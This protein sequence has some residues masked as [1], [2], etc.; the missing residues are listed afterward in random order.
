MA[1]VSV[2]MPT[3]NKALYLDLTLAGFSIQDFLNFELIIVD[4]GSTDSTNEIVNKYFNKINIKYLYQNN[5]GRSCARNKALEMAGSKYII[6]NDDDRIPEPGFISAHHNLL[7]ADSDMINIGYKRVVL[8]YYIDDKLTFKYIP[9]DLLLSFIR[10]DPDKIGRLSSY[11]NKL[12][13]SSDDIINSFDKTINEWHLFDSPDNNCDI[14]NELTGINCGW[15]VSTTGNMSLSLEKNSNIRFDENY[16]GWGVE[17]NDFSYQLALN[18][19][20]FQ[21]SQ[22][23][24]NYHQIHPRNDGELE[25]MKQNLNYFCNKFKTAESYLFAQTFGGS[26]SNRGITCIDASKILKA[27]ANMPD[28]A[29]KEQYLY[30]CEI[31]NN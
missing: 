13:F 15:V 4:D 8:S 28:S 31:I 10:R 26:L 7:M 20:R 22:K 30:M 27:L 14:I 19:Y 12:L 11:N 2:I 23:I 21:F 17:D 3:Y 24:V 25:E 9:R 16:K 6:F 18:G 5:R 1:K 29:L